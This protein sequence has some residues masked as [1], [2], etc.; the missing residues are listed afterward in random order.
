MCVCVCVWCLDTG[1]YRRLPLKWMKLHSELQCEVRGE[2]GRGFKVRGDTFIH[3]RQTDGQQ[4]LWPAEG[5]VHHTHTHT[6]THT[7]FSAGYLASHTPVS[8]FFSC[9]RG[10]SSG[11]RWVG[12]SD[13]LA[14]L[15]NTPTCWDS[16]G[17]SAP[18][19][20]RHVSL[21]TFQRDWRWGRYADLHKDAAAERI[22]INGPKVSFSGGWM[23]TE[24]SAELSEN[25]WKHDIQRKESVTFV[26]VQE[27]KGHHLFFSPLLN[28]HIVLLMFKL[29][30]KPFN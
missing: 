4:G 21:H 12:G 16:A 23:N 3:F 19:C 7:H 6:H 20:S 2:A 22:H 17:R 28:T 1:L 24:R 25:K 18:T 9:I 11:G 29:S 30:V 13:P 8:F 14:A 26:Q 27:L 5:H 10:V 15:K